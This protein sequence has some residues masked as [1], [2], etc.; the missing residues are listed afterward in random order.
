M[1][2]KNAFLNGDLKEDVYIKLPYGMHT[3]PPNTVCKLKHSLY[4]LKQ[5]SRVW[6][7]KL[8]STILG[9]SFTQSLYDPSFFLQRTPKGIVVL[10]AYVDN[11]VVTSS[12]QKEI[13]KFKQMLHSTFH[14]KELGHLTYFLGLE[15]HYHLEGIFLNQQKYIQ[16]LIQLAGLTNSTPI[17]TS[18]EGIICSYP[19]LQAIEGLEYLEYMLKIEP[20]QGF[21][22]MVETLRVYVFV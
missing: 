12:D 9:F 5:D 15:V 7:E 20:R 18:L 8:H 22:T 19:M 10:L 13:S 14:M 3:P 21:T 2:V 1:D 11:I 17:D 6:F 4:G 16:D